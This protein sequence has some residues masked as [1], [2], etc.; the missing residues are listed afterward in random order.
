VARI[1]SDVVLANRY[2]L[3]GQL[4]S[5]GMG[6]VWEAEDTV[7]H[8]RVAV[9]VLSD[10]LAADDRFEERFLREARAA[11]GLSHQNVAG[12]FDYGEDK[13]SPFM[14]M[15]L[16][17]GETLAHRIG[18]GPLDPA[19]AVR[20]AVEV[21]DALQA[22]HDSGMVHR[23]VKPGNVMLTPTGDVKVMDFG[24][25]AAAGAS[26][27][28]ATGHTL[29]TATYIS[30]EQAQGDRVDGRS[31]VYSLGVVLF[32]MLAG[33]PPFTGE[34]P[35]A[36]VAAHA[37]EPPPPLLG[38]LP[39]VPAHVAAACER[40]LA[41]DPR[42]RPQSAAEFA[43][44]LRSP[45]PDR[46]EL[47]PAD[48]TAELS[49]SDGGAPRWAAVLPAAAAWMARSR[50]LLLPLALAAGLALL[51]TGLVTALG[52]DSPPRVNVPEVVG[53]SQQEAAAALEAAGLRVEGI[54][55]VEGEPGVV[56]DSDPRAGARVRRGTSVTLY[57]GMASEETDDGSPGKG[58]GKG[59]GGNGGDD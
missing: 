33:R 47:I 5:G 31:D 51:G 49:T 22:A 27:L 1:E 56:V 17:D 19:E 45:Q 42:D 55:F 36:M 20:I 34:S 2:R 32:E 58:K 4:S 6:S 23:D 40:A 21:A 52:N 38:S 18:I 9:K 30:P 13:G 53:S 7:L 50:G 59:K 57:V 14:V 43:D 16:I 28:T 46:T 37:Q 3:V 54:E 35:V 25:V 39:G 44:M 12:V 11:A 10:G 24:I 41:K 15:E 48:R 29:G 8:R 26:P